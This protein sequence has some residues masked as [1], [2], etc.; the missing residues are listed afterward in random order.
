MVGDGLGRDVIGPAGR[1]AEIPQIVRVGRIAGCIIAETN[2]EALAKSRSWVKLGP[3][4]ITVI[5]RKMQF[6]SRGGDQHTISV[7]VNANTDHVLSD[8]IGSNTADHSGNRIY[9]NAI[10][11]WLSSVV[12]CGI[13]HFGIGRIACGIRTRCLRVAPLIGTAKLIA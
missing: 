8:Q 1:I 4:W 5:D 6:F 3:K 10:A 9:G 2:V 13:R 11:Q 7:F 12:R